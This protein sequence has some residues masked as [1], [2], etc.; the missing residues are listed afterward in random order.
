MHHGEDY[1]GKMHVYISE[2]LCNITTRLKARNYEEIIF[3]T[4]KCDEIKLQTKTSL[5]HIHQMA[6]KEDVIPIFTTV[7]PMSL[8]DSSINI[9]HENKTSF[10]TYRKDYINY[11]E[12]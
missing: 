2:G 10:L 4:N 6:L 3:E 1:C 9:L 8:N 7:Y 12:T 11:L 5:Q